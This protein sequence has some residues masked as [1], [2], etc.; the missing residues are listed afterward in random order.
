MISGNY[1]DLSGING[2]KDIS[3]TGL[4]DNTSYDITVTT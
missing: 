2:T 1:Y 3:I 4:K